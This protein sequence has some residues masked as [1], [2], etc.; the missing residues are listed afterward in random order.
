AARAGVRL[1]LD[2]ELATVV[3]DKGERRNAMTP[4]TWWHLA[5]IGRAL[6]GTVRAVLLR[7]E[8][9]SFCAGLDRSVLIGGENGAKT[10]LDLASADQI[11]AEMTIETFQEAYT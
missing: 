11:N 6:P 10:L 4:S 9:S 2:G 3:L 1:R 8:G 7:A 5:E